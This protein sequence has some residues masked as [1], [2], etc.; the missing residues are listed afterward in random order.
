MS[1][2]I[3]TGIVSTLVVAILL[4]IWKVFRD[5]K[6]TG[7]IVFFLRNSKATTDNTFRSNHAISSGTNIS[8]ERVRNLCS[9][10]E[11]IKRNELEKESWRLI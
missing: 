1:D 11:K 8:E 5:K 2:Q 9:K 7:K 10:C 6:D 3:I 4:G